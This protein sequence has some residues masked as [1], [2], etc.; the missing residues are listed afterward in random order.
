MI[1]VIP[2]NISIT[3]LDVADGKSLKQIHMLMVEMTD[4]LL[5]NRPK[6]NCYLVPD[7]RQFS[8]FKK[9][10]FDRVVF[11]A[12]DNYT[13]VGFVALEIRKINGNYSKGDINFLAISDDY[14][15]KGIGRMLLTYGLN[16][17]SG[18]DCNCVS[19]RVGEWNKRA[20][21]L[22]ESVGFEVQYYQMGLKL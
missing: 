13:I 7:Y 10:I 2:E 12:K 11:V 9:Y 18:Q 20:S 14:R 22:Y 4:H 6:D 5:D 15:G 1:P 3:E 19:L 16:Y 8:D 17:M 21:R